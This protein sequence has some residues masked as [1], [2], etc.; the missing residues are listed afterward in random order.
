MATNSKMT[1]HP[2]L[3]NTDMVKAVLD[4][5]KAMTRR[6]AKLPEKWHRGFRAFENNPNG[7]EEFVIHGDCGTKTT[8]CP[9]GTVGDLLW[10]REKIYTIEEEALYY[11]ADNS[12]IYPETEAERV[13]IWQRK[14]NTTISSRYM[15]KWAARIW[16]KITDIKVEKVRDISLD[17]CNAEGTSKTKHIDKWNARHHFAKLW[18]SI[19]DKRGYGWD[20]NPFCW[21]IS[22]KEYKEI[23][24]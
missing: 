13:W 9:Y 17:D 10:V 20:V 23:P 12:V 14:I 19:N 16:L 1:E 15:P 2:I 24:K 4:G 8:Y 5:R 3:F 21:V 7:A 18:N 6:I 22:F 11:S